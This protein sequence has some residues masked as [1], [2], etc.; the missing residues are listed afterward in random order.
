MVLGDYLDPPE[1][2]SLKV[3]EVP[4]VQLPEEGHLLLLKEALL[5]EVLLCQERTPSLRSVEVL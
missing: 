5:E 2:L 4:Q 3:F 1:V